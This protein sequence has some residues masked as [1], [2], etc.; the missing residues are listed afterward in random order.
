MP[1]GKGSKY[2]LATPGSLGRLPTSM[3][4]GKN[5]RSGTDGKPYDR[6]T[7][8]FIKAKVNVKMIATEAELLDQMVAIDWRYT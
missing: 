8:P 6:T 4:D 1:G 7:A 5:G 3:L 2:A